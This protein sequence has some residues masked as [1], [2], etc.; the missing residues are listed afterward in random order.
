L[1]EL[2]FKKFCTNFFDQKYKYLGF[3]KS[4]PF[5]SQYKLLPL[6]AGV[7]TK[8]HRNFEDRNRNRISKVASYLCFFH[9]IETKTSKFRR[10]KIETPALIPLTASIP[11]YQLNRQIIGPPLPLLCYV[12]FV[13]QYF[14]LSFPSTLTCS[15]RQ[16]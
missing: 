10:S 1:N 3:N 4:I 16:K 5:Y 9:K 13:Y 7:E 15:H 11:Y 8:K 2:H 6:R 12:Y 14:D